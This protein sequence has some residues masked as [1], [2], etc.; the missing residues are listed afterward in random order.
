MAYLVFQ[1]SN[2]G[3]Y[4]IYSNDTELNNANDLPENLYIKL[5]ISSSDFDDVQLGIK[6]PKID[7][8]NN[9]SYDLITNIQNFGIQSIE[10]LNKILNNKYRA[11]N[12]FL[13]NNK[14]HPDFVKWQNYFNTL[15]KYIIDKTLFNG[16]NYP[17]NQTF[18]EFLKSK[19]ETV[20]NILQLP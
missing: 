9:I 15:N 1:K 6:F 16:I 8:Q 4:K 10:Q 2:K 12:D 17:L 13:N 7:D 3:L 18:E 19:G 14:N 20:L 11:V 5:I